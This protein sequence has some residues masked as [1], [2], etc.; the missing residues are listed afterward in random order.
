[1]TFKFLQKFRSAKSQKEGA[2]ARLTSSRQN[3]S[4]NLA[5][6][7]STSNR[8]SKRASQKS[9]LNATISDTTVIKTKRSTNESFFSQ[10][11]QNS[12]N[13]STMRLKCKF[14]ERLSSWN[15][16]V[17][18]LQRTAGRK[19]DG[20]FKWKVINELFDSVNKINT[21]SKT[22]IFSVFKY[23]FSISQLNKW[24]R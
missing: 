19:M 8:I 14:C 7:K 3:A 15:R 10:R 21:C 6:A 11:S 20:Q 1:M 17:G 13:M 9:W 2:A 22:C 12:I 18:W 24:G 16:P 4:R 5:H 23:D